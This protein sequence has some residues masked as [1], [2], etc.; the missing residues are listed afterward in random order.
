MRFVL[1]DR[2]TSFEP[3]QRGSALK[4]VALSEDFFDDHFPLKPIMPGVLILEG[5][6]QLSGLI[7]EEGMRQDSGRSVK[8]LMSIVEKAKFRSP[9]RPGDCLEYHAEVRSV[10]EVGGKISA[11]ACVGER[12]VA[13]CSLVFTFHEFDNPRLQERQAEIVS[14]LMRGE[15]RQGR[16]G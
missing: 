9:A 8:A 1:L 10:N 5:L 14:L 13:Q 4:S 16:T 7:L 15:T 3:G 12:V 6:A 11:R 2:I